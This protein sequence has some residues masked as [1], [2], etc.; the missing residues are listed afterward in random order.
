MS[1]GKYVLMVWRV[2]VPSPSKSSNLLLGLLDS[3]GDGR[4]SD[5]SKCWAL[6]T[7]WQ[8]KTC[9]FCNTAVSV[10]N[11]THTATFQ[12]LN[13]CT[14]TWVRTEQQQNEDLKEKI[15]EKC[16]PALLCLPCLSTWSYLELN[17]RFW[18][19][20]TK[21]KCNYTHRQVTG[22]AKQTGCPLDGQQDRTHWL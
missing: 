13:Y 6:F 19:E 1:T 20:K 12:A 16:D 18:G 3:E 8:Y 17:P 14:A 5:P 4:Y 22:T 11:F 9:I 10:S 7:S 21:I 2:T 15:D